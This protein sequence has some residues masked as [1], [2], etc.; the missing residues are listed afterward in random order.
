MASV[1]FLW[2]VVPRTAST[3]PPSPYV[4]VLVGFRFHDAANRAMAD[5]ADVFDDFTAKLS[6]REARWSVVISAGGR[7]AEEHELAASIDASDLQPGLF[8]SLFPADTPVRNHA[9]LASWRRKIRSFPAANVARTVLT[10]Q[11][12]L[13]QVTLDDLPTLDAIG[14]FEAVADHRV[15]QHRLNL[16]PRESELAQRLAVAPSAP[17]PVDLLELERFLARPKV[18]PLADRPPPPELDTIARLSMLGQHPEAM[19]RAGLLVRLVLED[20]LATV[21]RPGGSGSYGASPK[22]RIG[23]VPAFVRNAVD[24][25]IDSSA[26]DGPINE[27]DEP[28][29]GSR[30]VTHLRPWTRLNVAPDRFEVAERTDG[31][32]RDG[33]LRLDDGNHEAITF[34]H[35]AAGTQ[36]SQFAR[37]VSLQRSQL[38]AGLASP[39]TPVAVRAAQP[40]PPILRSAGISVVRAGA[41][42]AMVAA[43]ENAVSQD[44]AARGGDDLL[45]DGDDLARGLRVDVRQV[46]DE[47]RP[48][49]GWYSLMRRRVAFEFPGSDPVEIEDEGH[50]MPAPTGNLVDDDLYL[51]ETV[52]EWAGWSL[53]APRPGNAI[54]RDDQVVESI[55]EDPAARGASDLGFRRRVLG[56][57]AGS[58]P[59]LR[60]GATYEIRART[61]DVTGWSI[62]HGVDSAEHALRTAYRRHEPVPSPS[63]LLASE[64]V[65]GEHVDRMVVRSRWFDTAPLPA[66]SRRH[67]V[68]PRISQRLAE[69]HGMFDVEQ[70][71]LAAID[72]QAYVIAA[73][74]ERGT[75]LDLGEPDPGY[76]GPT[77]PEAPSAPRLYADSVLPLVYLPDPMGPG[78]AIRRRN[79]T[80]PLGSEFPSF[81]PDSRLDTKNTVT[82]VRGTWPNWRTL[83]IVVRPIES[84]TVTDETWAYDAGRGIITVDLP[85]GVRSSVRLSSRLL[86]D[87]LELFAQ[88]E[89]A[90]G[91][92]RGAFLSG[93]HW[94][95]TPWHD[96]DLVHAVMQPVDAPTPTGPAAL[97]RRPAASTSMRY[98]SGIRIHGSSTGS[99]EHRLAW[100]EQLDEIDDP[101][102]S[103][104][105]RT[106]APGRAALDSAG[107]ADVL[108]RQTVPIEIDHDFGDTKRRT[109]T[110]SAVAHT[111]FLEH[112]RAE[113]PCRA[114]VGTMQING[115]RPDPDAPGKTLGGFTAGTVRVVD[116]ADRTRVYREASFAGDPTADYSVDH[117]T[118][119]ITFH[120]ARRRGFDPTE[121]MLTESSQRDVVVSFVDAATTR[122]STR[123]PVVVPAAARP[124]APVV[125]QILPTFSWQYSIDGKTR[126]RRGGAV[127]IYLARPW[128]TS[129]EGEELGV[130]VAAD[131]GNV[132]APL[133]E[134]VSTWGADPI[135]SAPAPATLRLVGEDFRS[136]LRRTVSSGNAGA[137]LSLPEAPGSAVHVISH[138]VTYDSVR[139]L[140][141]ADVEL[142]TTQAYW[143]MVRLVV[144]RFQSRATT[145]GSGHTLNCSATEVCEF[146][147]VAPDRFVNVSGTGTSRSVRLRGRSYAAADQDLV[148]QA[149]VTLET[150]EF[151]GD[152]DLGWLTHRGPITM[153]RSVSNE[154]LAEWTTD[155]NV[156][157]PGGLERRLV[158]EEVERHRD[159][160]RN[161]NAGGSIGE[162]LVF[163]DIVPL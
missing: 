40:T 55:A 16:A 14:P 94:A 161:E 100:T 159:D 140:W 128:F 149:R 11:R 29:G 25:R 85:R 130:V 37:S 6:G 154:N 109:V 142:P 57:V 20:D 49:T 8:A 88:G 141:F 5:F 10:A 133:R 101:G 74:R 129:G 42:Q 70:R 97:F 30:R 60:F 110:I 65:P 80:A 56:P 91:A 4:D 2:S 92:V 95:L 135:R 1:E 117:R 96:L 7:N 147:Q 48:L 59:M 26:Q 139:Q 137:P 69:T 157:A 115:V 158:I 125:R 15:E 87:D 72:P 3:K 148:P 102:P 152:G 53:G 23:S 41:A 93:R 126:T 52:F 112:F 153:Q 163:L 31:D 106:A 89:Q 122:T 21:A 22:L 38:E 9:G 12:T 134:L 116:L 51:S 45:L 32:H 123:A 150:R 131:P 66:T 58:L 71:E 13:A 108:G 73:E 50:V 39:G 90:S 75:Y 24:P 155:V 98:Q 119:E 77:G 136:G 64:R 114:R 19:R 35:V 46:D 86:P 36:A 82:D 27:V 156:S 144:C 162:R 83:R 143:P 124:A 113:V 34:D 121:A 146:T 62:D 81:V 103:T 33:F 105:A 138:P 43:T 78:L 127:R 151:A 107:S 111:A 61:V 76:S 104:Q 28:S 132:P 99:V 118:G 84:R 68:P 120:A 17:S 54:G 67:V 63:V 44:S 79:G 160:G 47:G 18:E 145:D